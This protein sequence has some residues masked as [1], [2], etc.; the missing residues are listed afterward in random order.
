MTFRNLTFNSQFQFIYSE[1]AKS[2]YPVANQI[3]LENIEF[4]EIIWSLSGNSNSFFE[5]SSQNIDL[6]IKNITFQK[7]DYNAISIF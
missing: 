2:F 5:I 1:N 6:M 4:N 3:M 7:I